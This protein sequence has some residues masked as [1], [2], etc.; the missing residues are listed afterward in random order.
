MKSQKVFDCILER[1]SQGTAEAEIKKARGEFFVRIPD[2]REDDPCYESLMSCFLEWYVYERP[3]DGG[4]A[5]PLQAY[6]GQ[7]SAGGEERQTLREMASSLHSLFLVRKIDAEGTLLEEIFRRERLRISERRALVGLEPGQILET[8]I[9]PQGGKLFF[10]GNA[11]VVHPRAANSIILAAVEIH[12]LSGLP[13]SGELMK[14]FRELNFR[15]L[16]RFRQRVPVEKVYGEW[17]SFSASR[18]S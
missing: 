15:Y 4:T 18:G 2:L 5:T 17:E 10:S 7:V 1:L 16:D 3:L 11:F 13:S 12:R 14:V 9:I 6:A 8:R